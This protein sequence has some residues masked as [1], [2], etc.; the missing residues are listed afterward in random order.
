[1]LMDKTNEVI[2][3]YSDIFSTKPLFYSIENGNV[4]IATYAS[5]LKL[6]G[7]ANPIRVKDSSFIEL[8]LND[9]S[10]KEYSH[11]K[12]NLKE[13]KTTYD[14]CIAALE[15]AIK[16]R[17]NEK[18]AIPLSSGHDSG[19]IFQW[20]LLN[21]KKENC[22]YYVKNNRENEIV[23]DD[24]LKKCEDQNMS[25][26]IIDYYKNKSVNDLIEFKNISNNMEDF[27]NY[28]HDVV[29]FMLSKL[30]SVIKKDGYDVIISGS[31]A[32]AIMSNDKKDGVYF[33]NLQKPFHFYSY[34]TQHFCN[35]FEYIVGAYGVQLRYPFLDKIFVQEFLNLSPELKTQKYKSVITEYLHINNLITNSKK[36]GMSCSH[37]VYTEIEQNFILPQHE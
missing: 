4:G 15:N 9:L 20:F 1:M 35:E 16:I 28:K 11:S 23:M 37:N 22:F 36:V 18:C 29:V 5:E 33:Y 14:D 32:D 21:N 25:Y 10:I 31:G 8:K 34:I 19:A 2:Y 7:F 17:C 13:Y 24:R 26:K 30:V 3:L 12:F 6:L 27:E